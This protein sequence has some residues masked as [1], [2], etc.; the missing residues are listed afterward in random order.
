MMIVMMRMIDDYNDDDGDD[1]DDDVTGDRMWEK[2]GLRISS[3]IWYPCKKIR[4]YLYYKTEV[5]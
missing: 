1:N 4:V 2:N 5:M 3:F